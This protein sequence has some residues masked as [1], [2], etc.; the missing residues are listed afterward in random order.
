MDLNGVARGNPGQSSTGCVARNHEGVELA[1]CSQGL[2][3]SINNI[4]EANAALLAIQT[5]KRLVVRN[6]QLEGDS[7]IIVQA[8][9]KGRALHWQIDKIIQITNRQLSE[10]LKFKIS[11]VPREGNQEVDTQAKEVVDIP[12][13]ETKCS[14][15]RMADSE[16]CQVEDRVGDAQPEG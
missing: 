8:I 9:M 10:F 5:A 6:L 7:Q 3:V 16:F 13:G 1:S 11:H 14:F 4:V 12:P 15:D 2:A